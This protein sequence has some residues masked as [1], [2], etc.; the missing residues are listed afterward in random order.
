MD[1]SFDVFSIEKF[2]IPRIASFLKTIP[3]DISHN[4]VMNLLG[5]PDEY[6]VQFKEQWD[7]FLFMLVN[8]DDLRKD[9]I[10]QA[11]IIWD[12]LKQLQDLD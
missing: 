5:V 3:I 11:E 6:D 9:F 7:A 4:L 1:N 2:F 8:D 10:K 12:I